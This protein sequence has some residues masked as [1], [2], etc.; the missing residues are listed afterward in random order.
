MQDAGTE[1]P[2]MVSHESA[3]IRCHLEK[4]DEDRNIQRLKNGG[5]YP[6]I[7]HGPQFNFS[8]CRAL[9]AELA[10]A[11][12]QYPGPQIFIFY[13]TFFIIN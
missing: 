7:S 9:R 11:S 1:L 2:W 12:C 5:I 10:S 13:F 8:V 3:P 6:N 4:T